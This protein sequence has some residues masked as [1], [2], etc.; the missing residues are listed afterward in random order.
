VVEAPVIDFHSYA[1]YPIIV[2]QLP[3]G[4]QLQHAKSRLRIASVDAG[5]A[6]VWIGPFRRPSLGHLHVGSILS[7]TAP[8]L[9]PVEFFPASGRS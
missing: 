8:E 3:D 7:L 2:A 6:L 5:D 1:V 4:L 9:I